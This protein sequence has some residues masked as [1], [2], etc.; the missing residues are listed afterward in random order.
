MIKILNSNKKNFSIELNKLLNKRRIIN[1]SHLKTVQKIINNVRKHKDSAL[2]FYERKFNN[3][4]KIIPNKNQIKK[5]IKSLDPKVKKAIDDAHKKIKEWHSKQKIR[6]IY[7]TDAWNN[8]FFYRTVPVDSCALYIP[9]NLPSALLMTA[10]PAIQAGVP[11]IVVLTPSVN[12]VL[13]PAVYYAASKLKI[14]EVYAISG[15][16]AVAAV[17]YGTKKIKPVSKIIGAGSIYTSLAKKLVSLDGVCATEAAFLGPSEIVVWADNSVTAEEVTSSCIAQSEHDKNSMAILVT[18]SKKLIKEVK[19][20]LSK[21]LKDLPRKTIAQKSLKNNGALIYASSDKKILSILATISPEHVE[22]AIKN[23]KKYMYKIKNSGSV[24]LGKYGCM[25]SSDYHSQH[26][27]PCYGSAKYASGL[28]VKDFIKQI[29]YN[30]MT[31][32]GIAKIGQTGYVLSQEEKLFGHSQS[33][34]IKMRKK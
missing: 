26:Q 5:A 18:K 15:A 21:Q 16:S 22:I 32:K 6:D 11:R 24:V 14:S 27:L 20:S 12:G 13:D 33:I 34:K 7:Y 10:T 19:I 9:Q 2:V 17:A 31:K 28:G 1:K 8:K 25:A 4:S 30:E 29:S 23:Y 3:N